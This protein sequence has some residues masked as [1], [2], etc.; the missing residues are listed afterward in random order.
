MRYQRIIAAKK[1]LQFT[2]G[3][4]F[5]SAPDICLRSTFVTFAAFC[6]Q[7]PDFSLS[8]ATT[9]PDQQTLNDGKPHLFSAHL[10]ELSRLAA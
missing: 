9:K 5:L 8:D 2:F 6:G 1:K 4:G 3:Y 7:H 10:R